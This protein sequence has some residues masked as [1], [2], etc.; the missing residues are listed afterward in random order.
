MSG[1]PALRRHINMLK[2]H[3]TH[4]RL[5]RHGAL[6]EGIEASLPTALSGV[7]AVGSMA[8]TGFLQFDDR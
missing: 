5:L 1:T 2:H 6:S 8:V 7:A 4:Y 3:I